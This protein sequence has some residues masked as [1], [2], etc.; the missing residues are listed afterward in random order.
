[1]ITLARV[2]V[3]GRMGSHGDRDDGGREGHR[4]ASGWQNWSSKVVE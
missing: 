4:Q 2:A 1:M 3:V